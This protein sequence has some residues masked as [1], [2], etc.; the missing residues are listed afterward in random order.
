MALARAWSVALFGIDGVLVEIEADIGGGR[1]K[2]Q[3]QWLPRLFF[4]SGW[5]NVIG[6]QNSACSP[7][8]CGNL[9]AL[10]ITPI[11]S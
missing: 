4:H 11:T 2:T 9:K 1:P 5:S 3:I 7:Q 6:F 8:I 10:G